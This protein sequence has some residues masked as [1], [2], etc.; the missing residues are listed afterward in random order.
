M[1]TYKITYSFIEDIKKAF[2]IDG[3]TK[4][5][6]G[7]GTVLVSGENLDK[8]DALNSYGLE[9]EITRQ[10]NELG[11]KDYSYFLTGISKIKD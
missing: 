5:I 9:K 2:L 1:A 6:N 7:T 11:L 4:L 10:V 8:Q 3:E